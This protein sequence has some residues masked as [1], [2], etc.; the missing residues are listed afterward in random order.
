MD[1]N[2][3]GTFNEFN[4]TQYM[5]EMEDYMGRLMRDM[6]LTR[7]EE[8]AAISSLPMELLPEKRHHDRPIQIDAFETPTIDT[9]DE[10]IIDKNILYKKVVKSLE[11][12]ADK[13]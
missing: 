13:H 8:F 1:Y 7:G 11:Q 3:S 6:A 10:L 2:A 12:A 5:A 9:E 4:V